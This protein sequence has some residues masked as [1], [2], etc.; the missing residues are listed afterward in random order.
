MK[1]AASTGLAGHV[2]LRQHHGLLEAGMRAQGRLDIAG[3]DAD[4]ADLQ[5][6]V[7]A[8]DED[9]IAIGQV[10]REIAGVEA[11]ANA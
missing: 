10:P 2:L 6:L 4:A 3:L 1:Y 7:P 5:P 11:T 8:A 9:Q